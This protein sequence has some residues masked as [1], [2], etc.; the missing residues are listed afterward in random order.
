MRFDR[1]TI[2][3][4]L[5]VYIIWGSTYLGILYAI[6]TMP[7]LWMTVVRNFSAGVILLGISKFIKET[8]LNSLE[9]KTA[10]LTG[11]FLVGANGLV[12]VAEKWVPS[13]I[14]AV[15]I[16]AMPIWIMA[17]NWVSFAGVKP[18][19]RKIAGALIGV[20][21]IVLIALDQINPVTTGIARFGILMLCSSSLLWGIGTL[22]QRKVPLVKSIFLFS[23]IQVLTGSLSTLVFCLAFE[24]PWELDLMSISSRSWW[25]LA[26]LTIFGSVIAFTAF[27]WLSRTVEPHLVSTYALVNPLIAVLLGSLFYDEQISVKFAAATLAVLVGLYLLIFKGSSSLF[28]ANRTK[29]KTPSS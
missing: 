18:S 19:N 25:A 7:G 15:I 27:S 9:L 28:A 22:L 1:K 8:K 13:G 10:M 6:E 5:S 12:S 3:A 26:Y 21:G 16:G 14:T 29:N 20:S 11:V 4:F 23:S 24:R 2:L 17:L